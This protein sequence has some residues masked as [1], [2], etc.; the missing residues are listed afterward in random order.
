MISPEFSRKYEA[1]LKRYNEPDL[2][3]FASSESELQRHMDGI[4]G[5]HKGARIRL[6]EAIDKLK[7]VIKS[8][9]SLN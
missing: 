5:S 9:L 4:A 8:A 1:F 3:H 7:H 6:S 2:R